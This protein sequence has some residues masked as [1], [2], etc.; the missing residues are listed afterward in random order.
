MMDHSQTL[1][2][3]EAVAAFERIAKPWTAL[4]ESFDVDAAAL[5]AQ[6]TEILLIE[7]CV[8]SENLFSDNEELEEVDEAHAK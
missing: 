5:E 4:E 8:I 1:T 2:L 3:D 6:E 7:K